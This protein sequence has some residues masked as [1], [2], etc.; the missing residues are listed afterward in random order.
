MKIN[1]TKSIVAAAVSAAVLST[2]FAAHATNGYFAHGYG[3]KAKGMAGAGVAYSQDSLAAATNPAG[4]VRVGNRWDAGAEIFAP[5]R[6]ATT[7]WGSG[8]G[9]P[10]STTYDGNG[11]G[12]GESWFLIPEFGYNQMVG[13]K[14]SYGISVFG[15][16][17]MNTSYNKP[18]YS[19]TAENTGIDLMQLF[20]S[21]TLSIRLDSK[22]TLGLSANIVYQRFKAEGMTLFGVA[23]NGYDSSYGV[24]FRIGWMG[25]LTKNLTAGFTYQPKTKM[26]AF[27]KY[28]TLFAEGGNF[29][30]PANFALGLAW[31]A[32]PKMTVALDVE[33]IN[34]EGIKSISNPNNFMVDGTATSAGFGWEDMTIYK[35]GVDFKVNKDLVVR[36]GWNHGGQP[37]PA[38]QTLFNVVAPATVE[39]H[40]TLGFTMNMSGGELSGYYMHAFDNDITGVPGGTATGP[41]PTGAQNPGSANIGMSQNAFGIAYGK[42]F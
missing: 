12:F 34:Y 41:G 5:D 17:G 33:R 32:T 18:I 24:S 22:N 6:T 26:Q 14:M 30:I 29:D 1:L 4:M 39:D 31:K 3:I 9:F 19:A 8:A 16:G 42:K 11:S 7:A 37:I 38:S 40:L 21:P 10:T 15:N 13:N 27:D 35:L 23:S 20:I 25:D 2:P 36:A 28:N